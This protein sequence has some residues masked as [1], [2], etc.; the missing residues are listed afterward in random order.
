S[1]RKTTAGRSGGGEGAATASADCGSGGWPGGEQAAVSSAET[2]AAAARVTVNATRQRYERTNGD[3][4]AG[5]MIRLSGIRKRLRSGDGM[6]EIL[7][8]IDL[9]IGRGESVAI[10]G[11][12]GSGKSTL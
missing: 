11:P 9:E 5:S 7:R 4:M 2:S 8:G 6:V 12:S 3:N 10:V 1:P